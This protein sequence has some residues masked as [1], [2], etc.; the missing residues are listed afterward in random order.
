[1]TTTPPKTAPT[2]PMTSPDPQQVAERVRD[3]MWA[4]DRASRAL[5][6][7]ITAVSPGRCTMQMTVREDMLNGLDICHGGLVTT[8][9]DIANSTGAEFACRS[10]ENLPLCFV[11]NAMVSPRGSSLKFIR[12]GRSPRPLR[13]PRTPRWTAR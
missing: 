6:M 12:T 5:G 11:L 2:T 3:Q 1:M 8:H 10:V 9:P 4:N 13:G 7:R